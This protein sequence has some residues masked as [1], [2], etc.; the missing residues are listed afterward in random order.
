MFLAVPFCGVVILYWTFLSNI[1]SIWISKDHYL[2]IKPLSITKWGT[3][4]GCLTKF[5]FFALKKLAILDIDP[6]LN[7]GA[8]I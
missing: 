1:I 5:F 6:K 3:S 2:D 7:T 4:C 8:G